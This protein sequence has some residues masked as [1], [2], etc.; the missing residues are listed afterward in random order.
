MEDVELNFRGSAAPAALKN[1]A[2]AAESG[3]I[4]A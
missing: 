4:P 3:P 2:P 1:P